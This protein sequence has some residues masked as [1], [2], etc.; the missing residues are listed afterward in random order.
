MFGFVV[1]PGLGLLIGIERER[2]K[3][4]GPDRGA[5]GIRSFTL[6][7]LLG[8][9]GSHL[10]VPAMLLAGGFVACAALLSYLRSSTEDPGLT[11]E[12]ALLLTYLLGVL[13]L[14]E[15]ALAAALGVGVAILLAGKSRLH[16]FAQQQLTPQEIHDGLLLLASALIVL[17]LLPA[18]AIDPWGVIP[19]RKLWTLV[20]LIMAIGAAGHVALR[21]CGP[22]I[23]LPLAGFVGGFVSSS[24]TIAAMGQRAAREAARVDAAAAAGMA[25]SIATTVLMALLLATTSLTLL[26]LVWPMLLA[27]TAVAIL[28]TWRL[29]RRARASALDPAATGGRPF[30][31]REAILFAALLGA[32]LL[33]SAGLRHW[34]GDAGVWLAA[35]SAG[36][37]DVHAV[38]LSMGQL[39]T[40]GALD[41]VDA[42]FALLLG[43]ASNTLTKLML[44]RR[45]GSAYFARLWPGHL[46]M[47]AALA[48]LTW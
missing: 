25:S 18:G 42:R 23:G 32:V 36:L 15:P 39:V 47:L 19:I 22:R 35:A 10:G 26:R 2:R 9:L 46:G 21:V 20:V 44:A 34:L 13:A 1:A 29:A 43:F 45:A 31:P 27:G 11:T 37:A 6:V 28:A 7:A 38:T 8:A 24:A 33:V 14:V 5:A 12:I 16:R 41:A 48:A 17:P 3:G 40:A 4:E 30:D